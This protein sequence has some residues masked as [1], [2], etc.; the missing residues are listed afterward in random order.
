MINEATLIGRIGAKKVK[1][2][3]NGEPM[4]TLSVV[5]TRNWKDS[6]GVKQEQNTWHNVNFFHKLSQVVNDNTQV[7]NLIYIKG[8]I[9]NKQVNSGDKKGTWSYY[10]TATHFRIIDSKQ[11]PTN[12]SSLEAF[13]EFYDHLIPF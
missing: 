11:E 8:E 4:V 3:K 12:Y 1:P 6:K 2:T 10:I 7:G 9:N 5:T 13:S